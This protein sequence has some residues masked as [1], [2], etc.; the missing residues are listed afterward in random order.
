[1][2]DPYR[3]RLTAPL[4]ILIVMF[5]IL[6][7]IERPGSWLF[8]PDEARY[9]EIPQAMLLS[10]DFLSP[11]LNGSNYFEKPPLLY[12]LNAVSM[13]VL[14]DSP[15]AARLPVRLATLG[16][17]LLLIVSLKRKGSTSNLWAG[18]VFLSSLGPFILGRINITDA[19]VSFGLTLAFLSMKSAVLSM[20]EIKPFSRPVFGMWIGAAIAVL[21][22]GL[23]GLLLPAL[24]LLGWMVFMRQGKVLFRILF[25]PGFIVFLMAVVP[26]FA[27]M[28]QAHPGYLYIFFV[29]EHFLRY[30]TNEANRTGSILYYVPV[31]IVGLLPWTLYFL[32]SIRCL[33]TFSFQKIRKFPE[34]LF[35]GLWFF[36]I[37]LF[38][39]A[40]HSKL[41][42]YL[43]PAFPAAA[44]LIG[45]FLSKN[46]GEGKFLYWTLACWLGV[47]LLGLVIAGHSHSIEMH[48]LM[49]KLW[50]ICFVTLVGFVIGLWRARKN[51]WEGP[52][53]MV[54]GWGV[55]YGVLIFILPVLASD[56][57]LHDMAVRSSEVKAD[58]IVAFKTYPHSFPLILKRSIPVVDH[59]DELASDGVLSPDFFWNQEKF[60]THWR[61]NERMVVVLR[62]DSL[63][64]FDARSQK[65]YIL[66]G[67]R[68]FVLVSNFD[69]KDSENNEDKPLN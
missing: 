14:G 32:A 18:L 30:L 68:K 55:F 1:M 5:S 35:F 26:W 20:E 37:I 64:E 21:S 34:E 53:W 44:A 2:N 16:M 17:A 40:S 69:F 65:S 4:I 51:S 6:L 15:Y 62:K 11:K 27:L 41:I 13:K 42:P 46:N 36:I 60:W 61:S 24:V 28:E 57:S 9:A 50:M 54:G 66:S 39:S 19:L 22:K 33:V 23:I 56:Y 29:R 10:G 48:G 49:N 45:I 12:W 7:F 59:K 31:F 63:I 43:F 25:S 58:Q 52:L 8:D 3:T 67:N 38:F 47:A